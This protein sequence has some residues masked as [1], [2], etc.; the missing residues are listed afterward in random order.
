MAPLHHHYQ[1]LGYHEVTIS[2]RFWIIQI[3]LA[4]L[5]ILTIITLKIDNVKQKNV[6]SYSAPANPVQARRYW[7]NAWA[8]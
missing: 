2:V 3:L 8:I 1:K 6:S 5:A 4:V 7:P